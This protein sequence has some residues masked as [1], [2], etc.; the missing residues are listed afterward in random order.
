MDIA[1][2]SPADSMTPHDFI[3]V[4]AGLCTTIAT[5]PQLRKTWHSR[6][7]Q[8]VSLRTFLILFVGLGLW[9]VYGIGLR[10]WPIAVTNGISCLLNGAMVV[11]LLLYGRKGKNT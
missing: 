10:D 1:C 9:T 11:L 2:A 6:H 5:I 3:G 7:A 8:D 4:L